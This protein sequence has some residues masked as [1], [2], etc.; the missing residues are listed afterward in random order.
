MIIRVNSTNTTREIFTKRMLQNKVKCQGFQI[1]KHQV[2]DVTQCV[3]Q[4]LF[5]TIWK[6]K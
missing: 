2:R 4:L 6:Q 3:S 1:N 5:L